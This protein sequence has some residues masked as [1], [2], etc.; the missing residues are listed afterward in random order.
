MLFSLVST[1]S[2]SKIGYVIMWLNNYLHGVAP[3][4]M[5]IKTM[6]IIILLLYGGNAI[7][8]KTSCILI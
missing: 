7:V 8:F 1:H 6:S 5:S 2:Y 3:V 4:S